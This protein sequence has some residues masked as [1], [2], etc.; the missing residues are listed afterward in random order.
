MVKHCLYLIVKHCLHV[1]VKHCLYVMVTHCLYVIVTHC[2]YVMVM[3]CLYVMVKH[4]LYVMVMHCSRD[5]NLISSYMPGVNYARL[6]KDAE[7][8]KSPR[9]STSP[10]GL[11]SQNPAF[12]MPLTPHQALAL[13]APK[14]LVSKLLAAR[15]F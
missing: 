14:R 9:T 1:M 3:H 5:T 7:E 15:S 2:L 13:V 4:C 6:P 11:K 12:Y 8:S 10:R